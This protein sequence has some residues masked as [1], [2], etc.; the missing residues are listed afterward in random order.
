[1]ALAFL[2]TSFFSTVSSSQPTEYLSGTW[3][4]YSRRN[5]NAVMHAG[6]YL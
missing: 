4:L 2:R 1:M 5:L 3:Q 6:A